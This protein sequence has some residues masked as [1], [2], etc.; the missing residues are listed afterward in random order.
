[1]IVEIREI[2]LL[3]QIFNLAVHIPD[4]TQEEFKNIC[5]DRLKED[6]ST[7]ICY[8]VGNLIEAFVFCT[9]D[10][11]QGRKSY[12]IQYAYCNP[13]ADYS[14]SAEVFARACQNAKQ[15]NLKEIFMMTSRNP[16][17]F[18]RKYKFTPFMSVLRRAV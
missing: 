2:F 16:E 3:P 11:Y 12:V 14:V 1:M 10:L 8:K 4:V 15:L 7:F 9:V 13:K 17:A 5:I 18:I 6:T